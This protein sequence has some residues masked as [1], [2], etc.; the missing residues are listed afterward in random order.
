MKPLGTPAPPSAPN[1]IGIIE[2]ASKLASIST[3]TILRLYG[4]SA[5]QLT[6]L[7][8]HAIVTEITAELKACELWSPAPRLRSL[9]LQVTGLESVPEHLRWCLIMLPLAALSR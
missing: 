6:P 4:Q 9:I 1:L 3:K 7:E 8:M 5:E 2:Y